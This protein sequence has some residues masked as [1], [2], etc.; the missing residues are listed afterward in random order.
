M[1][2]PPHTHHPPERP[3]DPQTHPAP[4][5]KSSA[6]SSAASSAPQTSPPPPQTSTTP[7]APPESPGRNTWPLRSPSPFNPTAHSLSIHRP[8]NCHSTLRVNR[9]EKLEI[10]RFAVSNYALYQGSKAD[11]YLQLR[12]Y[13]RW[14]F[15]RDIKHPD[16]LLSRLAAHHRLKK[17][18][19]PSQAGKFGK[20]DGELEAALDAWIHMADE[21]KRVRA[22]VVAVQNEQ[23][24]LRKE[25]N[26]IPSMEGDDNNVTPNGSEAADRN[27]SMSR[28][29]STTTTPAPTPAMSE[30]SSL[31]RTTQTPPAATAAVSHQPPI[32]PNSQHIP[33]PPPRPPHLSPSNGLINPPP[34]APPPRMHHQAS[35]P[36]PPPAPP[37]GTVPPPPPH[38]HPGFNNHYN[39][40]SP[41]PEIVQIRNEMYAFKHEIMSQLSDIKELLVRQGIA[42]PDGN[43]SILEQ[44]TYHGTATGYVYT[45]AARSSSFVKG[46]FTVLLPQD[47]DGI[48]NWTELV[49]WGN[50][51][52]SNA[53][54]LLAGIYK[55]VEPHR[56]RTCPRERG[57]GGEHIRRPRNPLT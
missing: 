41:T 44:R 39:Y 47:I 19:P 20:P 5:P 49:E 14:R 57:K 30:G 12:A 36:P 24:R 33:P 15:G 3:P 18:A 8:P 4:S 51:A 10:V 22:E 7:S 6:T 53:I 35:Y 38:H 25:A 37:Y 13:C 34:P 52:T 42:G 29:R 54:E 46:L 1:T 9:R 23:R 11:F 2:E 26:H 31:A 50:I 48:R 27:G 40:Y 55:R 17:L 21:E 16:R 45:W 28:S 56:T 43:L 32:P